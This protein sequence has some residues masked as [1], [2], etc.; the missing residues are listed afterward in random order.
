TPQTI[1]LTNTGTSSLFVSGELHN[2]TNAL[3]FNV[4]DAQDHCLAA[5]IPAGGSCTLTAVFNPTASGSRSA[6]LTVSDSAPDSPQVVTFNGTGVSATGPTPI[7]VDTGGMT[8]SAG[9]CDMLSSLV[10]NFYLSGFT[11]AGDTT[12]PYT[13]ALAGGTLPPG[14]SLSTNGGLSGT[15]TTAGTY[16]F[17]VRVTDASGQS[18]TQDFRL[19]VNPVPA[20]GD[21]TCQHAPSSSNAALTGPA[22][23]G[24]TPSGEGL[25]DQSKLTS[26]GGY[27]TITANVKDVNL[28][29]GT[30]LWVAVGRVVGTITLN[31]GSGSMKPFVYTNSLRKQSMA[32][33]RQP[34]QPG[35]TPILSGGF[36]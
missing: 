10:N 3:D 28:P 21:P 23:G 16:V 15:T 17:T 8:C 25:G 29:N 9:V 4:P 13:W 33:Y 35:A 6:T 7:S 26:C 12:P 32:I 31:N 27:I 19:P 11:V 36:V 14:L 24:R 30:V 20:P 1:T 5:T 22:I 18:A 2:G 34:P